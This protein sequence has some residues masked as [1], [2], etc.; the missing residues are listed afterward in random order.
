MQYDA[1]FLQSVRLFTVQ[2]ETRNQQFLFLL[3]ERLHC[4]DQDL[5]SNAASLSA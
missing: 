4:L 1:E 3:T 5:S 2:P